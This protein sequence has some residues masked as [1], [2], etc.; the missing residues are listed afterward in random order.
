[1]ILNFDFE[2]IWEEIMQNIAKKVCPRRVMR[3]GN[4]YPKGE[5]HGNLTNSNKILCTS[6]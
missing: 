3:T 6:N 5:N 4:S 1:M 2:E